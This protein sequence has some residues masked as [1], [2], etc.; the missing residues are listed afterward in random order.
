MSNTKNLYIDSDGIKRGYYVYVHKD[1]ATNIIFYVGKG[2]GQRAW[3][4]TQRNE[5]WKN[6]VAALPGGWDVDIVHH[7]LSEIEAFELEAELVEEH[8][9]AAATGGVLKNLIPGGEDP[10]SVRIEVQLDDNGWSAAYYDA[11]TFKNLSLQ[12]KEVIAASTT[13]ALEPIV[14]LL[15]YLDDEADDNDDEE[16]SDSVCIVDMIIRGILD[17]STEFQRRRMSWKDF[18][19]AMEE[20]LDDLESELKNTDRHH[21]KVRESLHQDFVLTRPLLVAMDSGNRKDAEEYANR[22]SVKT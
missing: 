12:E 11:R 14:N 2:S 6:H 1:R 16:L 3:D 5:V 10:A 19:V 18:V 17:A 9:G 15:R 7:D 8:G 21:H 13:D 20:G 22:K 4:A